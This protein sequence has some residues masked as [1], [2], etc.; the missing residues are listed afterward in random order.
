MK[1]TC[2]CAHGMRSRAGGIFSHSSSACHRSTMGSGPDPHFHSLGSC[3]MTGISGGIPRGRGS[4]S[5]CHGYVSRFSFGAGTG[6]RSPD[7][8]SLSFLARSTCCAGWSQKFPTGVC[9]RRPTDDLL[10]PVA[11]VP[12]VWAPAPP[13]A[14]TASFVECGTGC[15]IVYA[16]GYPDPFRWFARS[17][18]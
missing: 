11:A 15:H 4:R 9:P 8:S 6:K 5:W 18:G 10:P 3:P 12:F 2:Q 1:D 17:L 16:I 7:S 13:R 14:R